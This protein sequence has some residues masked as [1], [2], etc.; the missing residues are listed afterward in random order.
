[1]KRR[2]FAMLLSLAMLFTLAPT[3]FAAEITKTTESQPTE[4]SGNCGATQE[5]NVTWTLKQNNEG[6]ESPTYTLTISGNGAMANLNQSTETENISDGAGTYPWANLRDSITN[7]VIGDGVTSIGSKA[8]IAYTNVT[9]VSIGKDV[10]EIG[11]GALSQL[12]ACTMFDVS[13]G[14]NKFTTDATGALFDHSKKKLIAFPCG[15]SAA[16]YEIPNTVTTISYGAFFKGCTFEDDYN[17]CQEFSINY[18]LWRICI[19]NCVGNG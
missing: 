15:S 11:V 4:M 17:S 19:Y 1:M 14:N 2:F 18:W 13:P 6:N 7:I 8:F 9:S 16:T 10:S 12:S 5:D 3:A